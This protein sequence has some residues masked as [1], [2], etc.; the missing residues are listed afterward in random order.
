MA[1]DAKRLGLPRVDTALNRVCAEGTVHEYRAISE[2]T[3]KTERFSKNDA[4]SKLRR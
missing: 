3:L 4:E 1:S 2:F